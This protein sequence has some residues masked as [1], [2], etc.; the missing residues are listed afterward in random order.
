MPPAAAEFQDVAKALRG[1]RARSCAP[2]PSITML[3]AIV[4]PWPMKSIVRGCGLAARR[5]SLE[6]R[7]TRPD[8]G[9]FGVVGTFADQTS[10]DCQSSSTTS[11]KVPPTS[12]PTRRIKT[13]NPQL[14]V[15]LVKRFTHISTLCSLSMPW[16]R[17]GSSASASVSS[18]GFGSKGRIYLEMKRLVL[19]CKK[20]A[21]DAALSRLS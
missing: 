5:E 9:S 21:R 3:V 18:L 19:Q 15:R 11:V 2:L 16:A 20:A 12:I 8:V 10:P 17:Q 13:S 4:V 14:T 7:S 1:D 6:A